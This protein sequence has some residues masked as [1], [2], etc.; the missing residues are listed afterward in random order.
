M[1]ALK[2]PLAL[3]GLLLLASLP[4]TALSLVACDREVARLTFTSEGTQSATLSLAAGDVAFWTDL[5]VAYEGSAA[6]GYQVELSQAGHRVATASCDPL[7]KM[8][9]QL[10]W[11]DVERGAFH[12]RRGEGKM[13]CAAT[14][15]K[16]GPTL[17]QATLAFAVHPRTA[18][19]NRADLVVKQ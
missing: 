1:S 10:V 4:L 11:V 18:T 7:G 17:I 9:V 3:L 2:G 12:S 8:S 5:D 16:A 6:L 14:L 19:I 15:P 13:L